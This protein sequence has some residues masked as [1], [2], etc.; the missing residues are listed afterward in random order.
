MKSH[1][2]DRRVKGPSP[3][4]LCA[5]FCSAIILC[6]MQA[7]PVQPTKLPFVTAP[8]FDGGALQFDGVYY[9]YRDA[10]AQKGIKLWVPPGAVPVRGIIFHGNPGSSG[11]T[12]PLALDEHLQEFAARHGFAIA[13]VTWF[14]GGDV[15]EQTG[16]IIEQV[17]A[18]WAQ[19]GFHPELAHVPLIP[20]GSSNAGVTAYGLA[21]Y[22]PER[23]VCLTPNV[24][25]R[26]IPRVPPDAVLRVPALLHIGPVDPFFPLGLKD[27]AELFCHA[28]P[29]GARWAW[30]AE[31]GKGHE[32]RHIDDVDMKFYDTCIELRLPADYD[33]RSGPVTLIDLPLTNG[34][35]A[36]TD[37]WRTRGGS[38]YIAPY[39]AYDTARP[40]SVWL[41]NE[42]IAVLYRAIA[43]YDNPLQISL[44]DVGPVE[45]PFAA[46][47]LLRSVGGTVVE[48]G[49][50][51][52]IECDA[53]GMPD[54]TRIEFRD[55]AALLGR[56][57][58]GQTP[59]CTFT[60]DGA[61][62]VYALVALGYDSNGVVR[63]SYPLHVLVRDPAIS[64][65]LHAQRAAHA[66]AW[67]ARRQ[68]WTSAAEPPPGLPPEAATLVARKLQPDDTAAFAPFTNTP[69]AFWNGST[70]AQHIVVLRTSAHAVQPTAAEHDD[71]LLRVRA[72]YDTRGLYL[73]FE[74][75]DQNA[76]TTAEV[77]FHLARES[78]AVLW[79]PPP[80]D[81]FIILQAALAL[82]EAQ[83]QA[84]FG[85]FDCPGSTVRRNI[86]MPWHMAPVNQ[87]LEQAREQDGIIVR[88]VISNGLRAQEWFLPWGQVG[89]PG[90]CDTPP[91]GSRI[92]LALG[93][94]QAAGEGALTLRWPSHADVW[95]HEHQRGPQPN[96][97]GD[98]LLEE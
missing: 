2:A 48:P 18:A 10:Q 8:A 53:T 5:A 85:T 45:N 88:H 26:Y 54:W 78:S 16:R 49:T 82:S 7:M 52:V 90:M 40:Y 4:A 28:R 22:K 73:L 91:A 15:Y 56:V 23:I 17:L 27:T 76:S 3:V 72:A 38:T 6:H 77:D 43:T 35:L 11:D 29:R 81:H 71:E 9:D 93:Y 37:S 46:G 62:R 30:T 87:T 55:G 75:M 13:G 14:R 39:A 97:W 86:P 79:Q 96:P 57:E 50:R 19:M 41:P 44:R 65:A 83:Y 36:D 63:T 1:D 98:L 60:V 51:L 89:A 94:N 70:G 61:K 33:P 32:I 68:T 80:T 20:R 42:D 92:G 95:T 66:A 59:A 69:A 24:G 67:R 31:Q 21:C 84:P 64:S 34:W 58:R 25:P 47:Q 74:L 12:R